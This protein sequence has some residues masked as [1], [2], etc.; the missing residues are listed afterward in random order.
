MGSVNDS[1]LLVWIERHPAPLHA[2][3][4]V[5]IGQCAFAFGDRR[6]V[7]AVI[8]EIVP[9]A[10][11]LPGTDDIRQLPDLWFF[12]LIEQ[13]R[14]FRRERLRWRENFALHRT[15]AL[16]YRTLFDRP[17]VFA[18]QTV[19]YKQKALLGGL[20]Q[21][22]DLLTVY[23]DIHQRRRRVDIVIPHVV[24]HPLTRP[25]DFTGVDVQRGGRGAEWNRIDAVATPVVGGRR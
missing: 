19:N 20:N 4:A 1:N 12:R 15:I 22:R 6:R 10:S 7:H 14:R 17:D 3:G 21:R 13:R 24:V 2:A 25:D 18:R 9:Q 8:G 23:G 16:R 5:R 11:T